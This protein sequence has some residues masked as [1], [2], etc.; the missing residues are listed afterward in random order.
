MTGFAPTPSQESILVWVGRLRSHVVPG[1]GGAQMKAW[2]AASTMGGPE[3]VAA[4]DVLALRD[5]GLIR[6]VGGREQGPT[7]WERVR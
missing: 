6:A 2:L 4:A 5:A 3:H 1:P 7:R